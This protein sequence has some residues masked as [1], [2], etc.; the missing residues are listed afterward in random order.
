[1]FINSVLILCTTDCIIKGLQGPSSS[2]QL[3]GFCNTKSKAKTQS[4]WTSDCSALV[5]LWQQWRCQN[6]A[7]LH[8]WKL[9]PPLTLSSHKSLLFYFCRDSLDALHYRMNLLHTCSP[10]EWA[11][12][13]APRKGKSCQNLNL[14]VRCIPQV[15]SWQPVQWRQIDR[16]WELPTPSVLSFF[17]NT[18]GWNLCKGCIIRG[19]QRIFSNFVKV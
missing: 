15:T 4:N 3:L 6:S 5:K 19:Q 2:A 10:I 7:K 9:S 1:M 13:S 16:N 18:S 17:N 11:E 12:C 8:S 14:C